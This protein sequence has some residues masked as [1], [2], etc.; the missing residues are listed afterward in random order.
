MGCD[1]HQDHLTKG[2]A[3]LGWL[4][5]LMKVRES[6]RDPR[7]SGVEKAHL[8]K[9]PECQVCGKP[10]GNHVHHEMPVSWDR[11][12][13]LDPTNLITLCPTHHLWFGHLGDWKS[14]N[15]HCRIDC[16]YWRKMIKERPYPT[17]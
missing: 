14:R 3:M 6:S 17:S 12:K 11:S 15:P 10:W 9:E 13:E 7:W 5:S 4:K 16:R 2:Y 8:S 1:H